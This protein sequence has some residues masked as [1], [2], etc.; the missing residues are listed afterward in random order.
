MDYDVDQTNKDFIASYLM[1]KIY[2]Q[3]NF[4]IF[5]II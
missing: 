5:V 2:N 4:I 1:L 3:Y